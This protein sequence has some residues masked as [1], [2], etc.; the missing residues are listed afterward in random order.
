LD[1]YTSDEDG[2]ASS[3]AAGHLL[4]ATGPEPKDMEAPGRPMRRRSRDF[5]ARTR[6]ETARGGRGAPAGAVPVPIFR[7]RQ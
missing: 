3:P 6:R 1:R 2:A 5:V 4:T 7:L